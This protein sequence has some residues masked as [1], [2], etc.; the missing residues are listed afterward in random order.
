MWYVN[1]LPSVMLRK[2]LR[3]LIALPHR[4]VQ[5]VKWFINPKNGDEFVTPFRR[6]YLP[7]SVSFLVTIL[8]NLGAGLYSFVTEYVFGAFA[9]VFNVGKDIVLDLWRSNRSY[10]R[11]ALGSAAAA[12]LFIA[13]AA[14]VVAAFAWKT[15]V[16]VLVA[17]FQMLR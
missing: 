14:V 11:W 1:P 12:A 3:I 16:A 2:L 8:Y 4:A 5:L 7:T 15:G 17:L 6:H 13:S 10:T 9:H